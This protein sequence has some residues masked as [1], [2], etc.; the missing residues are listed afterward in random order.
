MNKRGL[1]SWMTVP[2]PFDGL[3][4]FDRD[5]R[6]A[7]LSRKIIHPLTRLA[8]KYDPQLYWKLGR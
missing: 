7:W 6:L 8:S 1:R 4:S 3:Q 2:A 5:R